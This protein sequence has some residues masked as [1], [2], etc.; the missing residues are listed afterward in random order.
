[1][2]ASALLA[3]RILAIAAAV[4]TL[5]LVSWAADWSW[6]GLA[7]LLAMMAWCVSPYAV[8]AVATRRPRASRAGAAVLV[9]TTVLASA[10][11]AFV[12]VDVF[13]VHLDAQGAL[14]LLFVPVVQWVG[15]LSALIVASQLE[16]RTRRPL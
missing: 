9:A 4:A 14:V 5:G 1:M 7:F 11:A 16:L 6:P 13:F 8:L 15:V 2:N 3:A 12:Y 10:F